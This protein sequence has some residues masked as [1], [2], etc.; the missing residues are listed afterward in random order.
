MKI[1]I[2]LFCSIKRAG[3]SASSLYPVSYCANCQKGWDSTFAILCLSFS[4]TFKKSNHGSSF[5]FFFFLWQVIKQPA[6][7]PSASMND[8]SVVLKLEWWCLF[9]LWNPEPTTDIFFSID[10]WFPLK[11]TRREKSKV[12]IISTNNSIST[13]ANSYRSQHFFNGFILIYNYTH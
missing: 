7:R 9:L 2:I 3:G 13:I 12:I 4:G 6:Y 11:F 10:S 1:Y 8:P 5:V